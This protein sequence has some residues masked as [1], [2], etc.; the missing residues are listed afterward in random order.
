MN[1]ILEICANYGKVSTIF[2]SNFFR[3]PKSDNDSD[4]VGPLELKRQHKFITW[5]VKNANSTFDLWT[6]KLVP[7]PAL[8]KK[9]RKGKE[10]WMD[11]YEPLRTILSKFD[12]AFH[13][14][15]IL[16]FEESSVLALLKSKFHLIT[17]MLWHS[18]SP[19]RDRN[20]SVLTYWM[21]MR[22]L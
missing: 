7:R 10:G 15:E 21:I 19:F 17:W 11:D 20:L 1:L 4:K 9:L 22:R 18:H 8:T 3:S 6:V 2:V 5:V 13:E 12:F 14:K 16:I